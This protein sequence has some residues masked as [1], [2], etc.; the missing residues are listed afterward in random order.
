MKV[1]S[2]LKVLFSSSGNQKEA[3]GQSTSDQ[4]PRLTIPLALSPSRASSRLA[5]PNPAS[6]QISLPI[7]HASSPPPPWQTWTFDQDFLRKVKVWNETHPE[8]T[9]DRILNGTC[10]II[11]QHNVILELVPDGPIPIRGFVRA[12]AHLVKLGAVNNF[13]TRCQHILLK[14]NPYIDHS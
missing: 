13:D 4:T 3:Q 14:F 11:D 5:T 8:N 2:K 7:T 9:L 12:L 10:A 6:S 1:P